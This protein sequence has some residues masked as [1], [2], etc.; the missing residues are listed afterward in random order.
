[1]KGDAYSF[2]KDVDQQIEA[3]ALHDYLRR[4]GR[5]KLLRE[6]LYPISRL[7]LHLKQPGLEVDVEAFEDD[8]PA[9]GHI[10][11]SGFRDQEFDVQVTS[12][13]SYDESLRDELLAAEGVSWGAG[14]IH[15]D[16]SSGK[17]IASP[18]AV[19]HDEHFKRI[20][21][22]AVRLFRK[23]AAIPYGPNTVLI[24]SFDDITLSGHYAW[25]ELMSF[26]DQEGGL[27][28]SAFRSVYLFN[29]GTN[30]LQRAA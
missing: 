15:R 2:A 23:K 8:G 18:G 13:Y 17:V 28:G 30:E 29:I 7:A 10:H 3:L 19:D 24:I 4:R 1:M 11:E 27:S 16:R 20:S 21:E 26:V 9:D 12:D 5:G 14:D 25:K 6:E 22:S